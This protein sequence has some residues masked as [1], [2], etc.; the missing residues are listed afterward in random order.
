MRVLSRPRIHFVGSPPQGA[1]FRRQRGI[2]LDTCPFW[3][4]DRGQKKAEIF[5]FMKG[6]SILEENQK[7]PAKKLH[8]GWVIFVCCFVMVMVAVLLFLGILIFNKV[9]KTFMD[10]V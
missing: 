10:T 3:R 6:S 9:Q 5:R 7:Q 2:C 1:G 4:Y 8:Y